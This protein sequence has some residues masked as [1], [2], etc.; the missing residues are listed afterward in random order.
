MCV[1]LTAGCRG[2]RA[3]GEGGGVFGLGVSGGATVS[4]CK[5]DCSECVLVS[6]CEARTVLIEHMCESLCV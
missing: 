6:I 2:V 5:G 1:F 3:E 4:V